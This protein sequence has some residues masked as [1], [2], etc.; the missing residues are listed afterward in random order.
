MHIPM[1]PRL[2]GTTWGNSTQ[3]APGRLHLEGRVVGFCGQFSIAKP[4]GPNAV[5]A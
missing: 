4:C 5:E 2:Q 1:M 3:K